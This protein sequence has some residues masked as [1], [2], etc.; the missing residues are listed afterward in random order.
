[1]TKTRLEK[2]AVFFF[3]IFFILSPLTYKL[4]IRGGVYQEGI[5]VEP[6]IIF[7]LLSVALFIWGIWKGGRRKFWV[8]LK[9]FLIPHPVAFLFYLLI[10]VLLASYLYGIALTGLTA[11]GDFLRLGKYGLYFLSFPLAVKTIRVLGDVWIRRILMFLVLA[12]FAVSV[13][14]LGR[15][16]GYVS[17]GGVIDFWTYSPLSRSVGFLGQYLD[18]RDFSVGQIQ[19]A[20]HATF[21]LYLSV[22]LAVAFALFSQARSFSKKWF[23]YL[24]G[25]GT[26]FAALLY[27]LSRGAVVTGDLVLLAGIVWLL[28]KKR[29]WAV[30]VLTVFLFLESSVLLQLNPEI[31]QKFASTFPGAQKAAAALIKV[32]AP[33][34][35]G[36][37]GTFERVFGVYEPDSRVPTPQNVVEAPEV[38]AYSNLSVDK[39]LSDR[40]VTWG[41]TLN[42]LTSK[43][44]FFLFGVG[45][46]IDNLR[47]FT[48]G[49]VVFPHSLFLDQW[50]RGGL[51]ALGVVLV[52]WLVLFVKTIQFWS[53]KND[54]VRAVGVTLF[55]FLVGW[56]LDNAF[57]GEQFFSDAPMLV[58]WGT[59]G[60]VTALSE[61]R[62][63]RSEV[64]KVL[65]AL[66]SSKLGGA[67]QVA[68]DLLSQVS[69]R[70]S[71]SGEGKFEFIVAAPKGGVFNKKFRE[72]GYKVYP[73]PLNR[74]GIGGFIGLLKVALKEKVDLINSHGKGAG[75]YARKVGVLLGIPV[76]QTFHG[77]HYDYKNPFA[78][79]FYLWLE[80]FLTPFMRFVI[81]VSPGQEKEGIRLRIFPK[82]KSRLVV[83][84]IDVGKF[85][86]V[87]VNKDS[88]R[89]KLGLAPRDFAVAV[90]ARFD[91]V[92]GHI[93]LINHIPD[94]IKSIPNL[95]V[96]F[97][98]GGEEQVR[99]RAR[100][101]ELGVQD[102]VVF[103][104]ERSD[105]PKILKSADALILPSFHEG[106]PLAVLEA[107]ACELPVIGA[108]VVG[109][110]DVVEDGRTGY[111]VSFDEGSTELKRA[112]G[113]LYKSKTL[114]EKLGKAGRRMVEEKF[115]LD[116]FVRGTLKVYKEA[117]LRS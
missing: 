79:F 98:G 107:Y 114:R 112:L 7:L 17:G 80:R 76:V 83:N 6:L 62:G 63:Q 71:K 35:Q 53:S 90:V 58:F 42:L 74:I 19:K 39:S 29:F 105:V 66:T 48:D 95:K 26:I 96:V 11:L 94:L 5:Y 87:R 100:A 40:V 85:D 106:M 41:E 54:L 25:V 101:R 102:S 34:G 49:A 104:G 20:A 22:V 70:K 24:L 30:L 1:M 15:I 84:G 111:L 27:T 67:P 36:I 73:V 92:K 117:L 115:S 97:V 16:Y 38:T 23:A 91:R 78:R 60:L 81:N 3:L 93:R 77:L 110:A 9:E 109:V 31:Y 68:Y 64:R 99:A 82:S 59:L 113:K 52:I 57:S 14:S 75:I 45:Y 21:G 51:L 103:L 108:D 10:A 65:I 32:S 13:V 28:L 86:R 4:Q 44:Q 69:K 12:G 37:I 46:S 8:R 47:H 55:A 18:L 88:L 43:P 50:V 56:F 116:R 2:L 89:K 61:I 72:L 33:V